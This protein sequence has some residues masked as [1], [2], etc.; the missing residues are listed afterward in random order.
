MVLQESKSVCVRAHCIG[1]RPASP[2]TMQPNLQNIQ[3]H[4]LA[5]RN[6]AVGSMMQLSLSLLADHLFCR[7]VET[8]VW[9]FVELRCSV[10]VESSTINRAVWHFVVL[11]CDCSQDEC[12]CRF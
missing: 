8:P 5:S 2:A 4:Q 3:Q 9:L 11:T 7:T 6:R 10:R 12:K 1:P